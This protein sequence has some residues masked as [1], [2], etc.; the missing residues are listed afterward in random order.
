MKEITN[1]RLRQCKN[2][3]IGISAVY[4]APYFKLNR[5]QKALY[6][7]SLTDAF[8]VIDFYKFI[9]TNNSSFSQKSVFT[10]NGEFFDISINLTFNKITEFDTLNF[11]KFMR[12]DLFVIIEDKMNNFFLAGL[13][14]GIR[15]ESLELNNQ[16]YNI[17]MSGKEEDSTPYV[18]DL[19]N[20]KIIITSINNAVFENGNNKINQINNNVIYN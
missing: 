18:N 17:S 14:N 13:A 6:N 15:N 10:D 2:S 5:A 11:S 1:G 8:P 3:I 4:I 19:I 12:Q 7:L 16:Q 9:A 20:S